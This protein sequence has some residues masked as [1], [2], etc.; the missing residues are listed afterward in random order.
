MDRGDNYNTVGV[1]VYTT[2]LRP[3]LHV[4]VCTRVFAM[5]SCL[6]PCSFPMLA[7]NLFCLSQPWQPISWPSSFDTSDNQC[8][9]Y[10][11]LTSLRLSSYWLLLW[12]RLG[13]WTSYPSLYVSPSTL[14]V[15]VQQVSLT[16]I[17]FPKGFYEL[18]WL[19]WF[20]I[21]P[22][23]SGVHQPV[24]NNPCSLKHE[25]ACRIIEPTG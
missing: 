15:P 17:R 10:S 2:M 25:A 11:L 7:K 12:P 4:H 8:V 18:S 24:A 5:M 13:C 1:S 14:W 3:R 19:V 22:L 16:R 9:V 21:V 20:N 23:S 6:P